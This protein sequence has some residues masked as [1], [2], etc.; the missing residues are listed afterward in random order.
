MWVPYFGNWIENRRGVSERSFA[1]VLRHTQLRPRQLII[2]CNAIARRARKAGRFPSF[3]DDDIRVAVREKELDLA[4]EIINSYSSMYQHVGKIV[5]ALMGCPMIFE[6][7]ELDRRAKETASQWP[8]GL[9]SPPNFRQL[10]A[11]LGIVGRIRKRDEGS[12]YISADFEYASSERLPLTVHDECVIHP[13][14][15]TR[16]NVDMDAGYLVMPFSSD[17]EA[18]ATQ[19]G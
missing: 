5:D 16:F 15:Y 1:Y 11:E 10:V 17:D 2:L 6:G 18:Q 4:N 12:R 13:M 8:R 7:R 19:E 14:F 9:Y 3:S